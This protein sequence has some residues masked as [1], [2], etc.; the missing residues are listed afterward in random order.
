MVGEMTKIV[1]NRLAPTCSVIVAKE[2]DRAYLIFDPDKRSGSR[3]R[4][5]VAMPLHG[6]ME[7][8]AILEQA[9]ERYGLVSVRAPHAPIDPAKRN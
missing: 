9:R 7:L 3:E 2:T 4:Y 1:V 6:A 5:T 8:L